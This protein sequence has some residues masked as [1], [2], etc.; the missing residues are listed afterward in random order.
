MAG[1]ERMEVCVRL[2]LKDVVFYHML[3]AIAYIFK[4][5]SFLLMLPFPR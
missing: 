1:R 4:M 3:S 2:P 5:N